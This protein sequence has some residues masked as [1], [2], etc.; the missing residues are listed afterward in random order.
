[1]ITMHH[2]TIL[3]II[4]TWSIAHRYAFTTSLLRLV[5]AVDAEWHWIEWQKVFI[6]ILHLL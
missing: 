3:E 6:R 5:N 1:M 4:D 2:Y